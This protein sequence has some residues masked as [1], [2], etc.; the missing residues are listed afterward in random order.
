MLD[1]CVTVMTRISLIFLGYNVMFGWVFVWK[2]GVHVISALISYLIGTTDSTGAGPGIGSESGIWGAMIGPYFGLLG[3]CID[4]C[5][6]FY[7]ATASIMSLRSWT[8]FSPN[9][10]D[11]DSGIQT[12][13]GT[14]AALVLLGSSMPVVNNI[15]GK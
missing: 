9:Y 5:V 13:M 12:T 6:L 14:T 11:S 2:L 3:L 15:L 4:T 8:W 7:F 1:H 10:S